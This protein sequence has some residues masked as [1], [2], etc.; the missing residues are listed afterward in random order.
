MNLFRFVPYYENVVY[1]TGREP[2]LVMFIAFLVT[3]ILTRGYTRIARVRGWGST[4]VGGVHMHHLVVGLVLA[5]AAAA[6][7]FAYL[8]EEG[9]FQLLLAAA[10]GSGAALVLDEFALIFHLEDVYWEEEGRKSVDA[11]VLGVAFGAVF[12]LHAAP[13]GTD[14]ESSRWVLTAALIVHLG[15][16]VISALKG[17]VF[18]ATFGFFIP[19][20]AW[21]GAIRLAEPDS[22]WARRRYAPDSKKRRRAEERYARYEARWR[23]RKERIWDLV[24]GETGR[25]DP[26]S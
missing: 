20:L 13:L 16:V 23:P 22:M 1:E 10:F 25:P 3:Y 8:P 6:I 17:K 21:I 15:F 4:H 9:F 7:E 26:G 12:L 5:F 18:M 11:V 24:G 2:A 19:T 14:G